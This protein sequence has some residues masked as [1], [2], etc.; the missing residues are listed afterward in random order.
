M[1]L[2][3]KSSKVVFVGGEM[4]M[5]DNTI[6]VSEEIINTPGIQALLNSSTAIL[7]IDDSAEQ[8]KQAKKAEEEMRAKI[9]AEERA[10]IK[11]E[12]EAEAKKKEAEAKKATSTKKKPTKTI[13]AQK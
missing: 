4:L 11:A 13:E 5:P 7:E 2:V 1:K 8:T 12:M 6:E 3:N 10:K 9:V